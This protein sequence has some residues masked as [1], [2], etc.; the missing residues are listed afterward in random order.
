MHSL[1]LTAAI[2]GVMGV[3]VIAFRAFI[4][5][6]SGVS[7]EDPPGL[8][9]VAIFSGD[10]ESLFADDERDGMLVG[11]WL[12]D[13]MCDG[14]AAAG[15]A[16]ENR[17]TVQ[18][19]QRAECVVGCERFA[20]VL[21]RTE[22]RWIAG[23][24]WVAPTAAERRHVRLTSQVFSPPDSPAVRQ[25]LTA[26]DRWLKAQENLS[27]VR[28][29]RKE[30]WTAEDTSDAAEE[31]VGNP[32][33]EV[34]NRESEIRK[35][36]QP[37]KSRCGRSPDRAAVSNAGPYDV[38]FPVALK[39][40]GRNVVLLGG[41]REA[42]RKAR[43]LLAAGARVTAITPEP[44]APLKEL[45]DS[46]QLTLAV[47]SYQEGDLAGARLVV[48]C[49]P[50]EGLAARREATER[51]V[52]LNVLDQ[53]DLCDFIAMATFS[54]DGLQL[55]VH[56]S[57][58]SGALSRRI[59]ERLE[60]E[61]GPA[62]AELT[63]LLGRLRPVVAEQIKTPA[64]RRR[65]WL[66]VITPELLDRVEAGLSMEDAEQEILARVKSYAGGTGS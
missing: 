17:G 57:G 6:P 30:A 23:V 13:A 5:R 38:Y 55:A 56:S 16:V 47:R 66:D 58:K 1:G 24:E 31:P 61:F 45:A 59:R 19:A 41:G 12:F 9:T 52:L 53:P 50:A 8:R 46:G 43:A 42:V 4:R 37:R 64:G 54:R 34:K 51:G 26:L 32:K 15:V 33:S 29:H 63:N 65:F 35:S 62:Y 25:L 21:E 7:G 11:V 10:D 28:W 14:L 27:D 3:V 44:S 36:N 20:L 60:S 22:S 39:L 49:D 18:F 2:L 48:A 40:A